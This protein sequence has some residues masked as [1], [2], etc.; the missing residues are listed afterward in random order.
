MTGPCTSGFLSWVALVLIGTTA[1]VT[2]QVCQ[3]PLG[4]ESGAIPDSS[5]TASAVDTHSQLQ[6]RYG[7]LQGTAGWGGWGSGRSIIGQWL[8]VDLGVIKRI[9]GIV[10]Q[11]AHMQVYS[12]YSWVTSYKLE[13]SGDETFWTTYANSNG[14][15]TVFTGNTD[16]DTPVTNLLDNP[17]NA[18]YVRFYPQSWNHRIAM[19]VDILGC[20]TELLWGLTLDDAG[21][22]HLN[23]SWTVVGSLPIS[24]Y[25]L[26]YQP[27]D[28][29]GS[30]KDL[31]PAPG[32]G[33]TSTA[34]RGLLAQTE[35]TLTLTSFDQGNQQNGEITGTFTTVCQNPLGMESGTIPDGSITASEYADSSQLP[36]F[37]RLKETRGWGG[38]GPGHQRT[39]QWLQVDFGMMKHVTGIL[40]QGGLFP[41]YTF[42]YSWVTSYKLDYS[43]NGTFWTTYADSG[44]S[45]KVFAGNTDTKTLVMNLL[46]DPVDAR[47]V[48]FYPQTWHN[49]ILMRVEILGCTTNIVGVDG[50]WSDWGPWSG[51]NVTCGVGTQSRDR[52]C[53]NPAPENGGTDCDGFNQ[54]TRECDTGVSCPVDGGWSD[55]SPWSACS[56]RCGVGTETRNRTCTNPAPENGGAD[57]DGLTQE[58]QECDTGVSCPVD[59]G[60]TDWGPWSGCSVT[61][62]VG[63]ETRDRTCTNP[64]PENGGTDCSGPL[65][66]T[67]ECDTGVFC[68]VAGLGAG[69]IAGIVVGA[70]LAV[71]LVAA[72]VYMCIFLIHKKRAGTGTEDGGVRGNDDRVYDT[73]DDAKVASQRTGIGSD[74]RE[75]PMETLR[76]PAVQPRQ[77]SDI[78]LGLEQRPGSGSDEYEVPMETVQTHQ[79]SDHHLE[80]Q[81]RPGSGSD[82]YEVPVETVQ[83][84]SYQPPQPSPYYLELRR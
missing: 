63:T 26:R 25:R 53:T 54:E 29:S 30:S 17:V 44:G 14:L 76:P 6:P 40:T 61:C 9:T 10:T 42:H 50:G 41:A 21:A 73:I 65:Q 45:D 48:R 74:K 46:D 3:N 15:D 39:G 56:V 60:W 11:G 23:V 19:R 8:Q 31:S 78:R 27:A 57:C 1:S 52:T 59:G 70:I 51:C 71:V 18:R 35:Y 79:P 47:Y 67:Q 84:L 80:L 49:R 38:W 7:R 16:T 66:E 24:R 13:Y 75:V 32:A 43:G 69:A 37:G 20:N 5:I 58:T 22:S 4:M 81:Q 83:P 55:W 36:Y 68:A 77:S 28:G 72:L 64:A 34:V 12:G 2:G 62:G 82:E 33:A